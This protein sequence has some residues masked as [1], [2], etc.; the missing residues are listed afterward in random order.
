MSS[1]GCKKFSPSYRPAR[2]RLSAPLAGA[3]LSKLAGED[4]P[5]MAPSVSSRRRSKMAATEG[6]ADSRQT[7]PEPPFLTRTG[8]PE[9]LGQGPA[10]C[11]RAVLTPAEEVVSNC[12]RSVANLVSREL[13]K[14]F[15]L[16]PDWETAGGCT[17]WTIRS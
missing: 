1:R 5:L 14:A 4:C 11:E 13:R 16:R 12:V 7:R 2:K 17:E 6:E 10:D 9:S 8:P 15:G 3:L